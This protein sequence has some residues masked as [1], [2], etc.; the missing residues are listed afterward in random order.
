MKLRIE[1]E[2]YLKVLEEDNANELF[3]LTKKNRLYLRQWLP[4]LDMTNSEGDTLEFISR[5][6]KQVKN[7]QGYQM[8][9][10]SQNKFVGVIAHHAINWANKST[11]IGYWLGEEF[12]GHG[13]MTKACA[14]LIDHSFNELGLNRIEIAVATENKKS[15]S[16][17]ERL[18]F[19]LEGIL[20]EKE[21]LYDHF[22]DHALYALLKSEWES[23]T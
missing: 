9:I 13:I 15:R 16:I 8:G 3:E 1:D 18:G 20:K 6:Q 5:G 22:V 11:S 23:T 19:K 17:P 2:L 12:N 14:E 21:W 10:W 4:W 7:N